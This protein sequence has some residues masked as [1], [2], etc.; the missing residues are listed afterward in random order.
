MSGRFSR[1]GRRVYAAMTA[2]QGV[3]V[4]EVI[5][6]ALGRHPN[7]EAFVAG[8]RRLTYA[9]SSEIVGR[10]MSALMARGIGVHSA[11][12]ACFGDSP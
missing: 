3:T 9:Q 1:T 12:A 5:V 6:D 4:S 8:E 10:L 2:S 7:R 11:V